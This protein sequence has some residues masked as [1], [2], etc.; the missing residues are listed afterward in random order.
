MSVTAIAKL[1]LSPVLTLQGRWVR[2]T[3]LRLAEAEGPRQGWIHHP[4]C[5][6][7]INLLFLGDSTMAG[8]GVMHQDRAL[9]PMTARR[10]SALLRRSVRWQLI[11]RSGAKAGQLLALS[12]PANLLDADVL[13]T[14][15]GGNDVIRQT[16][17][18]RFIEAYEELI[19]ALLPEDRT[20]IAI[21]SGLPPMHITPIVPQPLRWFF[22]R[23]ARKLDQRLER[24]ARTDP[25]LS[26]LSLQWA[27]DQ[28]KLAVDRFHP[29]EGLYREW[30]QRLADRIA[31]ALAT[32]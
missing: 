6:S 24:W 32:A 5:A 1:V 10:V 27:T 2:K 9:A 30:S 28:S 3:A 31:S 19:G 22:G 25:R 8:V 18:H 16:Q 7:P 13:I 11:A 20:A 12:D 14:A 17:P 15:A 23:F 21:I 29:G 26:Y 4:D